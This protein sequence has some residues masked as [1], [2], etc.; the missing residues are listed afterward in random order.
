MKLF[1]VGFR[2]VAKVSVGV[3]AVFV[4]VDQGVWSSTPEA[5]KAWKRIR[6]RYLPETNEYYNSVRKITS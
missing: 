1:S 4:T 6:S 5:A 2:T 3:A